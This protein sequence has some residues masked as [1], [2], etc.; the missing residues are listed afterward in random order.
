[1]AQTYDTF[2][3]QRFAKLLDE[4]IQYH[5]NVVCDGRLSIDEYKTEAGVIRGLRLALEA[6]DELNDEIRKAE[7]GRA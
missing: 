4:K 5:A 6:I 7:A 3:Q 2:W 1:M